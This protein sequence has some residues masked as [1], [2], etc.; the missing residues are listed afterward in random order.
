FK[1]VASAGALFTYGPSV[2]DL[3]RRAGEYVDRILKGEKPGDLPVQQPT[4]FE[5]VINL[6]TAKALGVTVPPTVLAR[7]AEIM[8]EYPSDLMR[9]CRCSR[10]LLL[11]F[12]GRLDEDANHAR[13]QEASEKRQGTKSREVWHPTVQERLWGIRHVDCGVDRGR[14]ALGGDIGAMG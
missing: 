13:Q 14:E 10:P 4:K 1:I 12:L 2:A 11:R 7:A 3:W 5:L 8:E 9:W 6:K